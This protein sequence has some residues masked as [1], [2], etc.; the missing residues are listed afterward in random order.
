[1]DNFGENGFLLDDS[2]SEPF[3]SQ[4][5]TF[6]RHLNLDGS[7]QCEAF[8]EGIPSEIWNGKNNHR[9]AYPGDHG[10]RFEA[11][12]EPALAKAS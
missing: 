7:K 1:M 11:L 6:C 3:L 12:V 8:P 9:T 5:C 10:I 4:V 2:H